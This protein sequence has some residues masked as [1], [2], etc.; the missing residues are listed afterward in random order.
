MHGQQN[1]KSAFTSTQTSWLAINKN[2]ENI[3]LD[4]VISGFRR[5][6]DENRALLGYYAERS[7]NFLPTFRDNLSVSSY[8]LSNNP[9]ERSF[10]LPELHHN[11]QWHGRQL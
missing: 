7:G 11:R 8:L 10:L 4:Y 6:V 9:E 5:K 2:S 3:F 1:I